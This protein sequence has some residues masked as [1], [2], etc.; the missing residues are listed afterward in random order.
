M[1][2]TLWLLL[3]LVL[4][5]SIEK[6]TKSEVWIE[7]LLENLDCSLPKARLTYAEPSNES[8]LGKICSN[9]VKQML[10]SSLALMS[11]FFPFFSD[12]LY[13]KR[14]LI[15]G[16]SHQSRPIIFKCKRMIT[17]TSTLMLST[18]PC[19]KKRKM[20]YWFFMENYLKSSFKNILHEMVLVTKLSKR[21]MVFERHGYWNML[22][23]FVMFRLQYLWLV[24]LSNS[25]IP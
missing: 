10:L 20:I 16:Y 4:R 18:L 5:L 2:Q 17:Q 24:N 11:L 1:K 3:V 15:T 25:L 21:P 14:P 8:L 12:H 19:G 22:L 13:L 9:L 7:W 23:A 6:R